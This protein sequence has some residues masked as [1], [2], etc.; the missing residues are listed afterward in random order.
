[1]PFSRSVYLFIR[2]IVENSMNFSAITTHF[3][4]ARARTYMYSSVQNGNMHA[5]VHIHIYTEVLNDYSL[6]DGHCK[7]VVNV[8]DCTYS[9]FY[10]VGAPYLSRL[11]I[12]ANCL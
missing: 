4:R 7:I 1:M 12:K 9:Y 5:C 8:Y 6:S 11:L 2:N 3:A 10:R